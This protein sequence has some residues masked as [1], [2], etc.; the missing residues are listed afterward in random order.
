[1]T[2]VMPAFAQV[3]VTEL[4]A[5]S[6]GSMIA[7]PAGDEIRVR[8]NGNIRAQNDTILNGGHQRGII[9]FDGPRNTTVSYS[10]SAGNTLTNGSEVLTLERFRGRN[11][12]F[13]IRRNPRTSTIGA[14]LIIPAGLNGGSFS[15]TYTIIIDNQ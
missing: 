9:E 13:T 4:Q 10:F 6:F 2:L 12:P 15:G 7:D 11:S 3:T 14:D 5:L 8:R 1:M